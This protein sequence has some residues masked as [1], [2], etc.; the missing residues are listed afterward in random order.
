MGKMKV[1]VKG[2]GI[3]TTEKIPQ[4]KYPKHPWIK[5]PRK[6]IISLCAQTEA[7]ISQLGCDNNTVFSKNCAAK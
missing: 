1:V 4:N 2:T 3:N 5:Y 7:V 6:K